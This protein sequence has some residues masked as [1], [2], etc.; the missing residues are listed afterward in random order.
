VTATCS[1]RVVSIGLLAASFLAQPVLGYGQTS[2][3]APL[4][5]P[6]Y[7]NLPTVEGFFRGADSVRLFYRVVGT[8]PE[9]IVFLHGGPGIGIEDGGLDLE[10]VAAKGFRFIELN[11]R[12]GG[13]SELVTDS[14]KLGIDY[15]VRDLEALR[16]HFE[17]QKMD[18]IGLSWGAPI[19]ALYAAAHPQ[20]I[21]RLIFPSPM[22]TT[23][24][25]DD[26]RTE[27]LHSLMT[28]EER[29]GEDAA[30]NKVA[31]ASDADAE[32]ICH[33]CG[34]FEDRLYVADVAHLSRARGDYCHYTPDAIRE[35]AKAGD[36][37]IETLGNWNFEPALSRIHVP[38]LVIEGAKTKVPLDATERWAKLLPNSRLVLIPDAGHQNWL[39]QPE[40][41]ISAISDFFHGNRSP[42]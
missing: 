23:K 37:T 4:T 32:M 17:L 12:G 28:K 22:A 25:L 33:R 7:D 20:N 35:G 40:A 15:Y 24:K 5:H 3:S 42:P 34:S 10:P 16:R 13:H 6:P 9:T 2:K 26:E 29:A 41:V 21:H 18:L 11:E 30:C 31:T 36:I 27:H 14:A 39:D 8:G 19:V 1:R 38:T